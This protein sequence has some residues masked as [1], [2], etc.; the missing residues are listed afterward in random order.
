MKT[1]ENHQARVR[2]AIGDYLSR[3]AGPG[4]PKDKRNAR[5]LRGSALL[6]QHGRTA[7][8]IESLGG[9]PCE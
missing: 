5:T 4:A 6:P 2:Q 7:G 1:R 3:Q 8:D 9:E